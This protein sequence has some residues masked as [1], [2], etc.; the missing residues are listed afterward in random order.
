MQATLD[1]R[2]ALRPRNPRPW[3]RAV[4]TEI[5]ACGAAAVSVSRHR[6]RLPAGTIREDRR[7]V[8]GA[9]HALRAM[10][11]VAVV[12]T[13]VGHHRAFG[14]RGSTV[15]GRQ[16]VSTIAFGCLGLNSLKME[17][18]CRLQS[19]SVWNAA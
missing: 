2:D 10:E 9:K 7:T 18:A 6:P 17:P 3:M 11:G 19:S 8:Q 13:D 4:D 1:P 12:C 16:R 14:P 15:S 5:G